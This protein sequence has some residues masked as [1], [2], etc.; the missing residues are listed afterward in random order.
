M[1]W[2]QVYNPLDN[3]WLSALIA[4]IPII[5]FFIALTLLKLKG[6]IAAGITVLLSMIIAIY[7]Y[8]MPASM[9]LGATGYGFLYALWPISYIIIG[10]VF[11]YKL[12]VK[13]G[14]FTTIRQSIISITDDPRLQMLLVAFSFNAFRRGSGIWSSNCH[15]SS[16]SSWTWVQTVKSSGAMFNC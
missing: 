14:Q 13:S 9:I 12:T 16:A 6:H 10:A 15:Y 2:T 4:L 5:F 1:T 8:D 11:L 7:F 3:I